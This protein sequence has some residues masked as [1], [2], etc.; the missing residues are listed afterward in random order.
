MAIKSK[1]TQDQHSPLT[2][3]GLDFSTVLRAAI[4]ISNLLICLNLACQ[5]G[6]FIRFHFNY[7]SYDW[8]SCTIA[9]DHNDQTGNCPLQ[10]NYSVLL[11]GAVSR[12]PVFFFCKVTVSP[13]IF[14]NDL[15]VV[16]QLTI[17]HDV[18]VSN[19]SV[20]TVSGTL[21]KTL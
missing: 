4:F 10:I 11:Y 16:C 19:S 12:L 7:V 9:T 13:P 1:W 15:L 14:S 8:L 5:L 18:P 2:L 3:V 6:F 21:K 17:F 20:K